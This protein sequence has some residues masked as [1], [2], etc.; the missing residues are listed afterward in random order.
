MTSVVLISRASQN[1]SRAEN[2]GNRRHHETG[3]LGQRM[4]LSTRLSM[5]SEGEG[6]RSTTMYRGAGAV[7]GGV[8]P[9]F[10]YSNHETVAMDRLPEEND[11]EDDE[12]EMRWKDEERR[13]MLAS[14]GGYSSPRRSSAS[15]RI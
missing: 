12:D 13:R 7:M 14:N 3:I 2:E 6:R 4:S 5:G 10:E 9:L 15:P 8:E 1:L 11:S